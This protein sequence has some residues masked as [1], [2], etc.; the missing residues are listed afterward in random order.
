MIVA[1]AKI[2][3]LRMVQI[4]QRASPPG[5][6]FANDIFPIDPAE[7]VPG[8]IRNINPRAR[9]VVDGTVNDGNHLPIV[10]GANDTAIRRGADIQRC[11]AWIGNNVFS[12]CRVHCAEQRKTEEAKIILRMG[13]K[14]L[15]LSYFSS[16]PEEDQASLARRRIIALS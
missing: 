7:R 16:G 1:T 4:L 11:W 6:T 10:Q 15:F 13:F 5:F 2:N 12:M 8:I 3:I 9:L 14:F